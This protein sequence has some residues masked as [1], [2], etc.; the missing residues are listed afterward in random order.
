[1]QIQTQVSLKAFNTL[2]LD[3]VASHY[4][5]VDSQVTLLEAL[6]Y[7]KQQQL[8]VVILS[9]GSNMLLPQR[10]DAVVLHMQLQGITCLAEDEHSVTLQVAAGQNW[11][12]FVLWT[13]AQHYYGLQNLALIP[14]LV[15]AAPVQNIGAYGVEVGEFIT[16]IEVYD[17]EQQCFSQLS[18]AQCDFSYR[19][20]V[21]KSQ[22]QRYV[23]TQVMFKL[24]KQAQL[25]INYGDL[26]IAMADDLSAE[27]LQRQV[28]QIRQSKLPD[29]K[30]YPN[31][32]SFFQNPLVEWAV[33]QALAVQYPTLPHYPQ[34]SGQVKLAAGWLIDQTGWKGKRLGCVGMFAQ[35]A[36]VLVNYAD[37]SLTTVQQTYRAV[38]QDV[39][40]KFQIQLEP[41]PVL[42][43]QDGQIL[44]HVVDIE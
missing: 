16:A 19:H 29:P 1:M 30:Q 32:G 10:L 21:F 39:W 14:G 27:N 24:L 15:G 28:I 35:Q 31:V 23:I 8:Q 42:F 11:H 26:K 6:A 38:Q 25:K 2:N 36:L 37:A 44:S 43:A 7:A 4:I 12:E 3:V 40:Q 5:A 18:A 22:P 9:G 20:S 13:T 41:E 34:P 33:Y 17:R